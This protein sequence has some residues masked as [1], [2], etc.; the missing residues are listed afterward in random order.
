MTQPELSRLVNGRIDAGNLSEPRGRDA[1]A[2]LFYDFVIDLCGGC[3][4]DLKAVLDGQE[5]LGLGRRKNKRS[6]A[7]EH[8]LSALLF[9]NPF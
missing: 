8:G 9:H 7:Q 2:V 3:D 4:L 6:S 5:R 1:G